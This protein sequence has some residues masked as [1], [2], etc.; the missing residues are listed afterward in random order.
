MKG[1]IGMPNTVAIIQSRMG[2]SRLP[3]KV[4]K[5]IGGQ[6]MLERIIKRVSNAKLVNK[7][8]IATSDKDDDSQI[9]SLCKKVDC[10]Y[11]RG[12]ENNVLDRFYRAA[13]LYQADVI[14]RLTADNA[15]VDF[16]L[17]DAAIEY[18]NN[19]NMDY[20]RYREG[21]PLGMACEIFSFE[22]L[23]KTFLR[24]NDK[25]C[26]EHVTP[27]M[28]KNKNLFKSVVAKI[29]GDDYSDLRWTVDT[30]KDLELITEIYTFFNKRNDFTYD[31]ILDAYIIHPEWRNINKNIVQNQIRYCGKEGEENI[32]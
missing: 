24:A 13:K 31:E 11:Y 32:C 9:E 21:L 15:L 16:N 10:L 7:V 1:N 2:S 3:G 26:I 22:A 14:I 18:F 30:Q 17:I 20:L 27:F 28:Y 19:E 5:D 12:N 8:V 23:E 4:L 6:P 25:E 29:Q